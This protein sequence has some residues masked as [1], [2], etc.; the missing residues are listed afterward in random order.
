MDAETI[1]KDLADIIEQRPDARIGHL[2]LTPY[3]TALAQ[4]LT[5]CPD[6]GREYKDSHYC[7]QCGHIKGKGGGY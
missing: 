1:I 5:F 6:C 4:A 3:I 7:L 2:G